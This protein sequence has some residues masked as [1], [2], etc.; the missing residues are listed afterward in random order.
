MNKYT[1][2]PQLTSLTCSLAWAELYLTLAMVVTRFDFEFVG[3]GQDDVEFHT[4]QFI[5]GTKSNYG[6][7]VIAKHYHSRRL[8]KA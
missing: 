3:T 5:M 2:E 1:Y 7:R 6:I 8:N 4:D